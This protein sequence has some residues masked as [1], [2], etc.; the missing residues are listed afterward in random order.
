LLERSVFPSAVLEMSQLMSPWDVEG[1]SLGTSFAEFADGPSWARLSTKIM[2]GMLA[3]IIRSEEW[4]HY[5]EPKA[6][7]ATLHAIVPT[8]Y[9]SPVHRSIPESE[10]LNHRQARSLSNK[11]MVA[12]GFPSTPPEGNR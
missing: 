12:S 5:L 6:R 10:H 2:T 9:R 8:D 11:K 3:A 7:E 1:P 4:R